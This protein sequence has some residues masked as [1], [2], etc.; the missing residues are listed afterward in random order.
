MQDIYRDFLAVMTSSTE[1]MIVS[2]T[3]MLY[4]TN[5]IRISDGT[6]KGASKAF[7]LYWIDKLRLFH[8]VIPLTDC[9]SENM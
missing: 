7:V 1:A 4:L 8:D 9:M 2:G 6:W 3:L 5:V